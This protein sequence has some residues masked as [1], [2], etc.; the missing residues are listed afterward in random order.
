MSNQKELQKEYDYLKTREGFEKYFWSLHWF[1]DKYEEAYEAA[2]EFY[3]GIFGTNRYANYESFRQVRDREAREQNGKS[4]PAVS[5]LEKKDQKK[6]VPKKKAKKK[7]KIKK[8]KKTQNKA[9]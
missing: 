9:I 4:K 2:N 7:A 1:F 6:T 5:D 8:S 3:K